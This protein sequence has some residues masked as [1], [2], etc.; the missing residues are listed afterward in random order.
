MSGAAE[1]ALVVYH[2][3]I[4]YMAS[5]LDASLIAD[6]A[7]RGVRWEH[8]ADVDPEEFKSR[9]FQGVGYHMLIDDVSRMMPR[10]LSCNAPYEDRKFIGDKRGVIRVIERTLV[11]GLPDF[12]AGM[13]ADA[14][15][16]EPVTG[17]TGEPPSWGNVLRLTAVGKLL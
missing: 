4:A 17:F 5:T 9:I 15:I 6:I 1:S 2:D 8:R 14:P 16:I 12:V 10:Q 7:E 13:N 11:S 3:E